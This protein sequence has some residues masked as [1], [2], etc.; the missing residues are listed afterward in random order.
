[1]S[2]PT[3]D[4][5]MQRVVEGV[6]W[7]PRCGTLKQPVTSNVLGIHAYDSFVQPLLIERCRTFG[8]SLGPAWSQLWITQGIQE[9]IFPPGRG[10]M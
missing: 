2:C 5:T 10:A 7:C 3:C 4:H 9:S 1:M 8:D 6:F